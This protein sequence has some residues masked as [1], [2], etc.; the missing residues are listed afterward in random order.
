MILLPAAEAFSRDSGLAKVC[1]KS[2][3]LKIADAPLK[4]ASSEAGSSKLPVT[5][6]TP[7]EDREA[8]FGE[9]GLRVTPRRAYGEDESERK[10]EITEPPWLP[11]APR[12]T[13][14]GFSE[15]MVAMLCC[16]RWY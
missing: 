5:I 15:D 7:A 3:T 11:V 16:F 12:T 4:A 13:R 10:C 1:Q 9:D 8:D 6:S 14:R 2:V